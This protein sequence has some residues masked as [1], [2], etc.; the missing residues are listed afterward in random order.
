M[1]GHCGNVGD[2]K[3]TR[4]GGGLKINRERGVVSE[5]FLLIYVQVEEGKKRRKCE[6]IKVKINQT[7][8][9]GEC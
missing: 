6:K 8:A 4:K 9:G 5:P 2:V 3:D 7:C 1:E